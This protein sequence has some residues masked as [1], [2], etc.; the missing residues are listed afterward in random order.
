MEKAAQTTTKKTGAKMKR[1]LKRW[2]NAR[3][4]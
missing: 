3:S 1:H 4:P 2:N